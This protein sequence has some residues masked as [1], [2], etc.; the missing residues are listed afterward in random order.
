[1]QLHSF[2]PIGALLAPATPP[3]AATQ[4]AK[5]TAATLAAAAAGSDPASSQEGSE[6]GCAS[7]AVSGTGGYQLLSVVAVLADGVPVPPEAAA[8]EGQPAPAGPK[9]VRNL[10]PP[11]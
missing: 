3:P 6:A 2:S 11:A 9:L 5:G 8:E 10:A 7:A 1:M 4:P